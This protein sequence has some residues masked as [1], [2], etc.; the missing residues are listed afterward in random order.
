MENSASGKLA[1]SWSPSSY[2]DAKYQRP[3]ECGSELPSGPF[4]RSPWSSAGTGLGVGRYRL[5][6][7]MRGPQ[8]ECYF[9]GNETDSLPWPAHSLYTTYTYTEI[10]M[11]AINMIIIKLKNL[12]QSRDRVQRQTFLECTMPWTLQRKANLG[13]ETLPKLHNN[14]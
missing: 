12:K 14:I 13:E 2:G 4:G 11:H 1:I 3:H 10:T 9:L 7:K 6:G 5:Q 8:S